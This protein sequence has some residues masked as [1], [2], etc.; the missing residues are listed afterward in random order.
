MTE[1]SPFADLESAGNPFADLE[2]GPAEMSAEANPFADLEGEALSKDPAI[3]HY[4]KSIARGVL[5]AADL[6]V[7]QQ[8]TKSGID[9]IAGPAPV[10]TGSRESF[11]E[12]A[13]QDFATTDNPFTDAYQ[14]V[15]ERTGKS[16]NELTRESDVRQTRQQ[17]AAWEAERAKETPEQREKRTSLAKSLIGYGR[18]FSDKTKEYSDEYFPRDSWTKGQDFEKQLTDDPV[19]AVLTAI[20]EN[21]ANTALSLTA[22]KFLGKIGPRSGAAGAVG[23]SYSLESGDIFQAGIGHLEEKYRGLE[24]V[25]D[26][27][28]GKLID[29]SEAHGLINAGLDAIMPAGVAN[30]AARRQLRDRVVQNLL[31]KESAKEIG[32]QAVKNTFKELVPELIQEGSAITAE[33]R[34]GIQHTDRDVRNRMLQTG[35]AGAGTGGI[36][37]AL[38]GAADIRARNENVRKETQGQEQQAQ[39]AEQAPENIEDV[40]GGVDVNAPENPFRDLLPD[41]GGAPQAP[42]AARAPEAAKVR[43][44][45]PPRLVGTPDGQIGTEAQVGAQRAAQQSRSADLGLNEVAG[46]VQ[47]RAAAPEQIL[48]P[49]ESKKPADLLQV[50]AGAG[51]LNRAEAKAQGLDPESFKVKHQRSAGAYGK[52]LKLFPATGGMSMDSLAEFLSQRGFL[53]EG[54]YSA[55]EALDLV[56]KAINQ[57]EKIYSPRAGAAVFEAEADQRDYEQRLADRDRLT[58]EQAQM[59]AKSIIDAWTEN[60]R[61][62]V[63]GALGDEAVDSWSPT[64]DDMALTGYNKL[65]P[66]AKNLVAIRQEGARIMGDDAFE[67]LFESISMRNPDLD[68]QAFENTLS[69]SIRRHTDAKKPGVPE[70]D[71]RRQS[72]VPEAGKTGARPGVGQTGQQTAAEPAKA[73]QEVAAPTPDTAP[74]A[75][76]GASAA[77][78]PAVPVAAPARATED[79]AGP[80]DQTAQAVKYAEAERQRKIDA[81]P[82]M[83]SGAG[84]L[85]SEKSKQADIEDTTGRPERRKDAAA[86][87]RVSEMSQE[88]MRAAL[89]T[90]VNTGLFNDRAYAEHDKLPIQIAIDLDSLKWVNDNMGHASGDVMLKAMGEALQRHTEHAYRLGGDEFVVQAENEADA[91]RIMEAVSETLSAAVV[92]TTRPDGSTITKTGVSFSYGYGKTLQQADGALAESKGQRESQGL[93]SGRGIE[94][95]GAVKAAPVGD[96]PAVDKAAEEEVTAPK[97]IPEKQSAEQDPA[98]K[99]AANKYALAQ[100]TVVNVKAVNKRGQ[101]VTV[102][103]DAAEALA[104]IDE[105]ESLAQRLLECLSN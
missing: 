42:A 6:A 14:K 73:R 24:N 80:V 59:T 62:R 9:R 94:P 85:F 101:T 10:E 50:I 11:E 5:S 15:S 7:G 87:K 103:E 79:L 43:A 28:F 33:S 17:R 37:G 99:T 78:S 90:D 104:R 44:L 45:P 83:E 82:P 60:Q 49:D 34:I 23:T 58:P 102:K 69:E 61:K 39:T 96:Q 21:S 64:P 63:A 81:S 1:R 53:P 46:A 27:Q 31:S 76:Q 100:G 93:R 4:P 56:T 16:I 40:L 2:A 32:D 12:A 65:S 8:I 38:S 84:D 95:P 77:P 105:Q 67:A 3:T 98:E 91:K 30:N 13:D 88:E 97:P 20:S 57:D 68:G 48:P 52:G 89:L 36:T 71:G 92:T 72:G 66:D 70:V 25:P 41:Q 29:V 26:D 75:K 47:G 54:Q 86:R 51:G 35:A 74:A 19:R 55:N 18:S 22:A